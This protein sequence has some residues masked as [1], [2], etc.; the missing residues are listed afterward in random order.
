MKDWHFDGKELILPNGLKVV[1]IK[2]D[3]QLFS[4]NLGVKIGP[5]YE[6][7]EEKG[8]SHFIEHMLFKGTKNR[9]NESLNKDLENLGGEYNAYTDYSCTVYSVSALEEEIHNG[10]E[11]LS[12]MVK[13]SS[14][15]ECELEK[16]RGV[17]LAEIRT[18]KDDIEDYS[19]KKTHEAAF[20][21]SPLKYDII[22]T[23]HNV[24][25]FSRDK[26]FSFYKNY[27]TPDNSYISIVSPLDHNEAEKLILKYF[28]DWQGT[29]KE[30]NEVLWEN[31]KEGLFMSKK[32]D[33]EQSTVV[34]LYT[35]HGMEKN[36]ELPL[37]ILSHNLGESSNS[38]LFRELREKRGLAYDVYTHLDLSRFI[39]TMAIYTA[40]GEEAVGEAIEVINE[41]I[42]DIRNEKI[43]F[44]DDTV[45]LMKKVH[46]TAVASTLEDSAELCNY[47]VHQMLEGE[48]IY[49][50]IK[51]MEELQSIQNE[52]I[53]EAGRAVL[54]GP[55]IHV[56]KSS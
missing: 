12:D 50:F 47:V 49:E 11:L 54:N 31:N 1:T 45:N 42:L 18:S 20:S 39:K 6:I 38:I 56:L 29:H 36:L 21:K 25:A 37:K 26:L 16:E 2:R 53:Y 15:L 35:F 44:N 23:E 4:I 41:A 17:I 28:N 13:N 40:V 43:E 7:K 9:D 33:I 5:L 22:G 51:D 48:S 3:T 46:K 27:Y 24:K 10:L 52:D 32:K 30:K 55:T 34:Y 14:F 8:I 19:F